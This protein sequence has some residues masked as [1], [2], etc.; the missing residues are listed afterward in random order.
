V[1][2]IVVAFSIAEK[3]RA[4]GEE[5]RRRRCYRIA[6]RRMGQYSKECGDQ[7]DVCFK[8]KAAS[9][10]PNHGFDNFAQVLYT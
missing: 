7:G 2:W 9:I 8:S 6:E 3:A 1:Y 4:R 5:L 10:D